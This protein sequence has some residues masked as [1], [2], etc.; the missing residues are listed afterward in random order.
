MLL[1]ASKRGIH[2]GAEVVDYAAV[3]DLV[4]MLEDDAAAV[5]GLVRELIS[6][7]VRERKL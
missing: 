7:R 2:T 4:V 1:S 5:S 6:L 3:E